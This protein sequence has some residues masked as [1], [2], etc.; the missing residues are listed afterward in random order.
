MVTEL[1]PQHAHA[2]REHGPTNLR[3][4]TASQFRLAWLDR[5]L[6]AEFNHHQ[7][8]AVVGKFDLIHERGHQDQAPSCTV[9]E[10]F[11]ITR[12]W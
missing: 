4:S 2:A 6:G 7:F 11:W 12:F 10:R 8:A 1:E 5:A 9:F 3:V